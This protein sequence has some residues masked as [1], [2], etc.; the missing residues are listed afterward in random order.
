MAS[1]RT[2][3]L[4]TIGF[5]FASG[6]SDVICFAR[7]ASF[8]ALMTGNTVKAGIASAT[9]S[10]QRAVNVVYYLC[11]VLSY[12]AGGAIFEGVKSVRPKRVGMLLAPFCLGMNILSDVLFRFVG[13]SRWQ[14]CLLAPTFGI[15]NSMTFG[16]EM[17]TNTTIITGNTQKVSQALYQLLTGK[18]TRAKA[19]AIIPPLCA[20]V[21]TLLASVAG[22]FVLM[23][24]AKMNAE[25]LFIPAGVLQ[26]S[27]MVLH[28]VIYHM[29]AAA[30][31]PSINANASSSAGVI[32]AS[33]SAGAIPSATVAL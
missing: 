17:A 8:A 5:A 25:W 23:D 33:S 21:S 28:D 7:Y 18:M 15:Q 4:L 3:A 19:N 9:E 27:M 32:E 14:V 11:I 30:R 29:G 31:D 2:K 24:V 10:D 16:G 13:D 26:S 12:I 6:W 20:I 22:A 1:F